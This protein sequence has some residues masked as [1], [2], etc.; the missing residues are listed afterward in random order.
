MDTDASGQRAQNPTDN[1]GPKSL[2]E[3]SIV[4]V[5]SRVGWTKWDLQRH[6]YGLVKKAN[7]LS[8]VVLSLKSTTLSEESVDVKRACGRAE[9]IFNHY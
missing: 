6:F 1:S 3:T 2:T 5:E 7:G 8:N 4:T 9:N